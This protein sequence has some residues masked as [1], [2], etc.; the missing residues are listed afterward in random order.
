MQYEFVRYRQHR[1]RRQLINFYLSVL[2]EDIQIHVILGLL[3][4]IYISK[5]TL[6]IA[7]HLVCCI[8][9]LPSINEVFRVC[10][11]SIS[12]FRHS[13]YLYF[14]SGRRH[15]LATIKRW[16]KESFACQRRVITDGRIIILLSIVPSG[17][18][19]EATILVSL[20]PPELLKGERLLPIQIKHFPIHGPYYEDTI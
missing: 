12:N 11:I 9:P 5:S 20:L 10:L 17:E 4:I 6:A 19:I 1:N 16:D 7:G 2:W 14:T 8:I 13:H 15:S 3:E 18:E